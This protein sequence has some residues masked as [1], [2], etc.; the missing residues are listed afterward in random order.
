MMTLFDST[1]K[2]IVKTQNGENVSSIK[3]VEVFLLRWNLVDHQGQIK[4]LGA[5]IFYAQ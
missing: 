1:R 3:V 5:I 2:S 4:V